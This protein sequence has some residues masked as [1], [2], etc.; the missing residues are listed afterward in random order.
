M[1]NLYEIN[2]DLINIIENECYID[3]ETGEYFE[4]EELYKMLDDICLK[5]D[6]KIEN[7]ACYIK[8]LESDAEALKQEKQ[9]LEK[10]QKVCEN[11]ANR[12]S[13]YLSNFLQYNKIPKFETPKCK[14]SFRKS[15]KV[16]IL[17]ENL[18]PKE[19]VKEEIKTKVDKTNLKKYLQNNECDGAIIEENQNINIK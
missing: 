13:E 5:L 3:E 11:K 15:S 2:Q 12:L 14:V 8:N 17:D 10:R 4:G 7:I 6:T 19:Y 9:N 1:A 18:I 16:K